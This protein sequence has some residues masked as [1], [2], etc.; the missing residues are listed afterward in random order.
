M[1][2]QLYLPFIFAPMGSPETELYLGA[3]GQGL[4]QCHQ[5]SASSQLFFLLSIASFSSYHNCLAVTS[6]LS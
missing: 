2:S 4:Q 5:D 3:W 1:F 6:H